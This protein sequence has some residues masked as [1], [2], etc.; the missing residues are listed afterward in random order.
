MSRYLL[1]QVTLCCIDTSNH[2]L[3]QRSLLKSCDNFHFKKVLY[4]S[5]KINTVNNSI[6]TIEINKISSINDYNKFIIY[7]LNDYIDTDYVLIVQWD[8]WIVRPDLWKNIF[9]NFDYIGAAWHNFPKALS[10][11]NGGFSLRSKRLMN[12]INAFDHKYDGNIPEDLFICHSMRNNLISDFQ[13]RFAPIEVAN[14]FSFER[15][16]NPNQSFGFHGLFNFYLFLSD[17][18][19]IEIF[20]IINLSNIYHWMFYEL[21][22]NFIITQRFEKLSL[23]FNVCSKRV[24]NKF[25][26]STIVH[27]IKDINQSHNLFNQLINL[28]F[29]R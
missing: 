10:V 14:L 24:S 7:N 6:H 4:F 26:L 28:N 8:S 17:Q 3:A 27:S 29:K 15:V 23:L 22:N 12:S 21:V 25:L 18:D 16:G 20:E 11:G 19:I 1:D 2:A 9:F 5:D 13:I